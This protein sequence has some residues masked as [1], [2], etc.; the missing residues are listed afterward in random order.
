MGADKSKWPAGTNLLLLLTLPI[1]S[2]PL[3]EPASFAPPYRGM[4]PPAGRLQ[5][6]YQLEDI[7]VRV[8]T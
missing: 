1:L 6:N 5:L 8:D 2:H 4:S 3:G 7:A